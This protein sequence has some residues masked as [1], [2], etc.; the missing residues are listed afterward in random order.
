MNNKVSIALRVIAVLLAAGA[1]ALFFLVRGEIQNAGD[2]AKPLVTAAATSQAP[3]DYTNKA[4]PKDLR[5]KM[6]IVSS[7]WD[8][9]QG[10]RK[11]KE[12]D[13]N[14][15]ARQK[16]VIADREQTIASLQTDLEAK[17]TEAAQLMR[18]RD[19]LSSK[20][21]GLEAKV[22]SLETFLANEKANTARLNE[23]IANMKTMEEY[24]A[25]LAEIDSY[26]KQQA[27]AQ[28]RY[29]GL[30]NLSRSKGLVIPEKFPVNL[31]GDAYTGAAVVEFEKAYI[32]TTIESVDTRKGLAVLNAGTSEKGLTEGAEYE[33]EIAGINVG[34]VLVASANSAYVS[35]QILAKSDVAAFEAGSEIKLIPFIQ[36]RK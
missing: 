30:R 11:Q 14:E 5:G 6:E 22:S 20:A 36:Q 2:K 3:F 35:V 26:E 28:A 24:Q 12:A 10:R 8:E 17:T 15:I 18:E 32:Y 1:V 29:T 33:V 23:K 7:A 19:D 27:K 16:T 21:S 25:K 31:Y 13:D 9:I 4:K 34:R